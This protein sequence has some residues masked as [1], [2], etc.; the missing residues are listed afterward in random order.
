LVGLTKHTKHRHVPSPVSPNFVAPPAEP[1]L[2][3]RPMALAAAVARTAT[4][5]EHAP[6][7]L[8]DGLQRSALIELETLLEDGGAFALKS[9][10]RFLADTAGSQFA[11]KVGAGRAHLYMEAMGYA[12]RANA[13]CLSSSL[14]PHADFVYDGGNVAGHGV[15][16]ADP[17][18]S[19]SSRGR[20]GAV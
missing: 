11:A 2:F 20:A 18:Y 8:L 13:I 5:R 17:L 19:Q 12:W 6:P 14:D 4:T 3:F 1:R 10:F 15:V 16:L 9:H 7:E